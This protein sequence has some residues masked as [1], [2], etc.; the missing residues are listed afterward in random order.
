MIRKKTEE[1]Y[2]K[3]LSIKNP[4]VI[5]IGKYIGYNTKT[6]H[7]CL[8]H[9]CCWMVKP[10]SVL[11]GYGCELCHSERLSKSKYLTKDEYK[12]RLS[13]NNKS[14]VLIGEYYGAKKKTTHKCLIHN[15]LWDSLP[16]N[17]LKGYGCPICSKEKIHEKKIKQNDTYLHELEEINNSVIPLEKYK[18]ANKKILHKCKKCGY[19][20]YSTPTNSLYH[21]CPKCANNIKRTTD[22]YREILAK[23]HS[24]IICLGEYVNAYTKILHECLICG[25]KWEVQPNTIISLGC[26]CPKC[27]ISRGEKII[28][29][30]LDSHDIN[31]VIQKKFPN[32]KDSK[33]LPFDF[34]L[35]N[36]NACI[37]YDG[38]QH[39]RIV[40]FFGG[41]EAFEKRRLHDRIKDDYCKEHGIKLLRIP[42]YK[43]IEEELYNF[44]F[45]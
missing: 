36:H 14:V 42:Y 16:S 40:D 11:K 17:M 44:L 13:K 7:K 45:T 9:D 5:L 29:K 1:E 33:H 6:L 23:N 22:E 15:Y 21:G 20:F 32:C 41:E 2:T 27:S 8:I 24:N 25:N 4:N 30:W 26:G 43:D 37:E 28:S 18:G 19:K 3:E 31:Y 38:E 35:P 34:Y 12:K 10:S 39:Y